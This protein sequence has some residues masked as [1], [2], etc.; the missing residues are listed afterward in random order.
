MIHGE[1][2]ALTGPTIRSYV[3][4]FAK[5]GTFGDIRQIGRPRTII[6]ESIDVVRP[7]IGENPETICPVVT[8]CP[9]SF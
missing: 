1:K 7:S 8:F 2:T 4:N 9:H 6:V 3:D 5:F